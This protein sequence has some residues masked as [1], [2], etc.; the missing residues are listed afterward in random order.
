MNAA[1]FE[2]T[3]LML[4]VLPH[5][6]VEKC[7]ALKGGT[8]INFFVRDMPRLS[9]DI[10]LIYLP[11]GPREQSLAE[12]DAALKRIKERL[13]RALGAGH[14]VR[15]ALVEKRVAK[16]LVTG[17]GGMVKVEPNLILRGT[18][19]TAVPRELSKKAAAAFDLSAV[20]ATADSADLY[21]G[22]LCAAL[23]RQHPRDLFDVKV[24]LENEGITPEIRKAFV[25]YLASHPRP[26]HEV[27]A[28]AAQDISVLFEGGFRGM[29]DEAVTLAELT[30]ARERMI[31][32]LNAGLTKDEK[33][34][35]LSLKEGSPDWGLLGVPGADKLPAI[36]WKLQ[37]IRKMAPAKRKEQLENLRRKLGL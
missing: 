8:A 13:S 26:M 21:G 23:D 14:A 34:F 30:A 29:T 37:N 5:V 33:A 36:Q 31:A 16:L 3:R 9:V 35:L 19:G 1:Y 18:V 20:I 12:I 28:P 4:R 2:Q 11:V 15:E 22:K 17:P 27:I 32:L 24:L 7:F 25:V 6:A 10:D